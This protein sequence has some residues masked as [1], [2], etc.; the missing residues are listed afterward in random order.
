MDPTFTF[1]RLK[2]AIPRPQ[3]PVASQGE[4]RE[5]N[6]LRASVLDAALELGL[7]NN[8]VVADWMFN[9]TLQEEEEEEEIEVCS[10]LCVIHQSLTAII[11]HRS[12]F[13]RLALHTVHQP[14]PRNPPPT[15]TLH[16]QLPPPIPSLF[17]FLIQGIPSFPNI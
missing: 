11:Y 15:H 6:A 7:A 8:S 16:L 14:L 3:A 1:P 13:L 10:S 4:S 12:P 17:L 2:P 9:N 5:S